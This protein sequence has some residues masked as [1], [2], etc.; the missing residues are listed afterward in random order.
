M[1]SAQAAITINGI[2]LTT[3][4]P[5]PAKTSTKTASPPIKMAMALSEMRLRMADTFLVRDSSR[6]SHDG[7]T[8]DRT[9]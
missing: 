7:R 4:I 1:I 8:L 5:I 2:M 9:W 3:G 6:A